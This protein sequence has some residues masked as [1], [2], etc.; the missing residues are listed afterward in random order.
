MKSSQ[1]DS[2]SNLKKEFFLFSTI[3]EE[4]ISNSILKFKKE[5]KI[6]FPN[7]NVNIYIEN[8]KSKN[9]SNDS[10]ENDTNVYISKRKT[11]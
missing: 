8:Q 6:A 1:N 3:N 11:N 4:T 10:F 2:L 9:E 7:I 5:K